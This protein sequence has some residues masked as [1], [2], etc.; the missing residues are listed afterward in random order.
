MCDI[1][2]IICMTQCFSEHSQLLLLLWDMIFQDLLIQ[3]YLS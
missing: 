3:I 1:L 2:H